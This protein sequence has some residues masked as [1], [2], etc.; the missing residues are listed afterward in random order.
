MTSDVRHRCET[1]TE[2]FGQTRVNLD[3]QSTGQPRLG[4]RKIADVR[5]EKRH[6]GVHQ[7]GGACAGE[8]RGCEHVIVQGYEQRRG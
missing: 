5:A 6:W 3:A 8:R 7:V 1:E 2:P 4:F